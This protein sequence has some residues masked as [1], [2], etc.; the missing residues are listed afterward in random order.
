MTQQVTVTSW[1]MSHVAREDAASSLGITPHFVISSLVLD[2]KIAHLPADDV[3]KCLEVSLDSLGA[4]LEFLGKPRDIQS[5]SLTQAPV[6]YH[7]TS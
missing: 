4:D 6:H 1:L 5:F 2:E 3:L 7:P